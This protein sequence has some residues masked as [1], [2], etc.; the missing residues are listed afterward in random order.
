M[1]CRLENIVQKHRDKTVLEIES[2]QI[3]SGEVVG[4]AGPNGSGKTTLLNLLACL[5]SPDQ[6]TVFFEDRPVRGREAQLRRRVALVQA[7]PYLLDRSVYENIAYGLKVRGD[8]DRLEFRV[9][10]A[11]Q[12]V[13]LFPRRFLS[14][15][16]AELSSG[17]IQRVAIASRLVLKPDLLLL[18]EPT[19]S[20][21]FGGAALLSETLKSLTAL[22]NMTVVIASHNQ[23]WIEPLCDRMVYLF[24]GKLAEHRPENFLLAQYQTD[25]EGSLRYE[26]EGV[27]LCIPPKTPRA[28]AP[29][30]P[31]GCIDLR[32]EPCTGGEN[33]LAATISAIRYNPKVPHYEVECLCA[34]GT[35]TAYL[36]A[37]TF[38]RSGWQPGGRAWLCFDKNSVSWY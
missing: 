34:L 21:D 29:M 20:I 31:P 12:K 28:I 24:Y 16:P 13:G 6:G 3:A 38:A 27:R 35:L 22:D 37:G 15:K 11:L 9:E 36:S 17:E 32:Q 1:N 7:E 30:V 26:A 19:K 8:Y 4:L 18:D 5:R 25:N 33:A 23:L 2:L 10:E 14:R